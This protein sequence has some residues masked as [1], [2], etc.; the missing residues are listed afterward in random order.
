VAD[1][2]LRGA[3]AE[4]R[5]Q[6]SRWLELLALTQLCEHG[7]PTI[8]DAR[9]LAALVSELT[10]ANDTPAFARARAVLKRARPN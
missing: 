1:S 8:D 3:L 2:S 4:S 9:A 5:A 7:T 6:G 10:E